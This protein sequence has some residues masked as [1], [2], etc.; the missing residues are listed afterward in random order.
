MWPGGPEQ[1]P[2]SYSVPRPHRLS[3]S[4]VLYNQSTNFKTFRQPKNRLQ[5]INT[6]SLCGLAGR[7][8]I[9]ILTRRFSRPHRL[10]KNSSTGL[11]FSKCCGR[12]M[13][14][15]FHS[16]TMGIPGTK[17]QITK[18]LIR[19]PIITKFLTIL[20]RLLRFGL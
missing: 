10:F 8:D 12:A 20:M 1:H 6:A 2:Y 16:K 18:F 9:P 3:K 13:N 11:H 5:R 4:K 14:F 19:V 7:Y 17:F 15:H